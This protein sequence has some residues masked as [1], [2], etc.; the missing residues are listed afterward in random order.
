MGYTSRFY[1]GSQ[2]DLI[3]LSVIVCV[4]ID[5]IMAESVLAPPLIPEC[6]TNG[7][8]TPATGFARGMFGVSLDNLDRIQFLPVV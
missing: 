3:F 8:V 2:R 5:C 4:L 1:G 7:A 6:E